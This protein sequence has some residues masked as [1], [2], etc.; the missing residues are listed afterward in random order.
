MTNR[1]FITDLDKTFLRSDLSISSFSKEIW[2]SLVDNDI[3]LSI[4]TARSGLKTRELLK[5]LKLS[6]PLIVMDGAMIISPDGDPM[7]SNTLDF[8]EISSLLDVTNRFNI[9]PFIIG[10]D[11]QGVERFQ[12]NHNINHFQQKLISEYKKDKRMQQVEKST[13]LKENVK[14]VYIGEKDKI[15]KIEQKL[16][17]EFQD[18]FEIKCQKDVYLDGY[19]LT[20]L[21]P[22][23]D[24]AHALKLLTEMMNIDSSNLSVFGD[25]HN[26]IGMFKYAGESIA[27]NN[28]IDEIKDLATHTLPHTNDEDGVARYLNKLIKPQN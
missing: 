16:I 27:V 25:S 18:I 9:S 6:H 20:I 12:Y 3:K 21:H 7:V 22:N 26:D 2:N 11:N 13:P 23:G 28:A 5:D 17:E 15:L 8:K 14:V 19:F 4:A 10:Y 1:L 24:K